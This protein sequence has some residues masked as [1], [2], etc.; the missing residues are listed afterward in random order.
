MIVELVVEPAETPPRHAH[1]QRSAT[2]AVG[3]WVK[4]EIKVYQNKIF[5]LALSLCFLLL[6]CSSVSRD[7][8]PDK[9]AGD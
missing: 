1:T 4:E 7:E 9:F 5:S 2:Q 6:G 3:H 8:T